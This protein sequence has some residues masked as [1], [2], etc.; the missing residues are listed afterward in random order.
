MCK[1]IK[2]NI[3]ISRPSIIKEVLDKENKDVLNPKPAFKI[4]YKAIVIIAECIDLQTTAA[5][6][7][8]K[9]CSQR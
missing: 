5:A 6:T 4:C 2:Q 3:K 1:M 7:T 9:P 8:T